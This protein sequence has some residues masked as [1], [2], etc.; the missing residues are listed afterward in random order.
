MAREIK[1]RFVLEGEQKFK[2]AM[3][4]A[5]NSMKVLN[6]EQK[7]AKA[8]FKATGDG[9]KYAAQQADILK[10][11]IEE[12]RKAVKAAEDAVKQLTNNGVKENDRAMQ[13]WQTKLNDART[14]LT[15]M[16]S[17]LASLSSASQET[18]QSTDQLGESL[19]N[20]DKKLSLDQAL[21][22]VQALANGISSAFSAAKNMASGV[23][24]ELTQAASW[25]D[26][27]LTMATMYE[28]DPEYLQ[29]MRYTSKQI[30][31]DV[32]TILS[33]QQRFMRQV[34]SDSKEADAAFKS[35]G[36]HVEKY[37]YGVWTWEDMADPF[38]EAG[39]ALMTFGNA[40]DREEIAMRLFGRSWHELIPLFK[41]GREEW[42]KTMAE[43]DVVTN[44]NVDKLGMLDDAIQDLG[45]RFEVFRNTI[46]ADISPTLTKLA[47]Q[48]SGFLKELNGYLNS[49][50]GQAALKSLSDAIEG[51]FEDFTKIEPEDVFKTVQEGINKLREGLEWIK[52]NKGTVI[53]AIEG[54]GVAFAGLKLTEGALQVLKLIEGFKTLTG[55]EGKKLRRV[56]E[57][58]MGG[59]T[60]KGG[61]P[62][63]SGGGPTAKGTEGTSTNPTWF[64]GLVTKITEADLAF[65]AMP[66]AAIAA[67]TG[68]MAAYTSQKAVE[69][70][71]GEYNE[72]RESMTGTAADVET[73]GQA[74]VDAQKA[75]EQFSSIDNEEGTQPLRDF[76]AQNEESVRTAT[77]GADIW[78]RIDDAAKAA[79]KTTQEVIQSGNIT[80]NAEEWLRVLTDFVAQAGQTAE[81]AKEAGVQI[82]ESTAEGVQEGT[83]TA[84]AAVETLGSETASAV[85]TAGAEAAGDAENSGAMIGEGLA[86]GMESKTGRVQAAA[87]RL[88]SLA[89]AAVRS[90][91]MI[92]SPSRLF[93]DIG[94]YIPLGFAEGIES[95][96]GVVNAAA[97]HM[98]SAAMGGSVSTPSMR[99]SGAGGSGSGMVDVT[100]MLGPE[101]LSEVLVPLVNDGIGQQMAL[102]R[103]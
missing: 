81:E 41:A 30:D 77:A 62:T 90:T 60:S 21:S 20:I 76:I 22:G 59:G 12:Q 32:T 5:A 17:E 44:E 49:E 15:N 86:V 55:S 65:K 14:A 24:K 68:T 89:A 38:W 84:T 26:E 4:D 51:L 1:T 69:R 83:S 91:A 18:A 10:R 11:K 98:V 36:I 47:E 66:A 93:M 45:S 46:L 7:L 103:R 40:A 79:G 2:S 74:V 54:I 53:T 80:A 25:A 70:D 71:Y 88:A 85:Q 34:S 100:L 33:A 64:T 39:Q 58:A 52:T 101:K 6:S 82:P 27:L 3:K 61:T 63:V 13:Q 42:E 31:T 99:L 95:Q 97:E 73:F 9:Q 96:L 75:I 94:Q 50:E 37:K 8:Q 23:V 92:K 16:E 78:A 67:I 102:E 29:R 48:L 35:L 57:D 43:Q 28:M 56:I 19:G 87:G 72:V